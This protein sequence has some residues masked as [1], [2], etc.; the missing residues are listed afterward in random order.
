MAIV[1]ESVTETLVGTNDTTPTFNMPAT[2][3]DGDF[4]VVVA[5]AD[6]SVSAWRANAAATFTFA[7]VAAFAGQGTVG[8]CAVGRVGSSEPASYTFTGDSEE[9]VFYVYRLSGSNNNI[10]TPASGI[11]D[12]TT[13]IAPATTADASAGDLVIR[14]WSIDTDAPT[15][16][17]G[18]TDHTFRGGNSSSAG[19]AGSA[20]VGT[21]TRDAA[22]TTLESVATATMPGTYDDGWAAITFMVDAIAAAPT[23]A[24][25]PQLL[26][27]QRQA[28]RT[29]WRTAV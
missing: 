13:A 15:Y 18:P 8:V 24:P 9:Y 25:P 23:F 1:V 14:A 4:Y 19:G 11:G 10:V 3:P 16:S 21:A 7:L 17:S 2:R 27:Y 6:G 29:T 22:T 26:R 5:G 20:Y 12:S 28:Q